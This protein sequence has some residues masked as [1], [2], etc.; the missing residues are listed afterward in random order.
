MRLKCDYCN[1]RGFVLINNK[2][3]LCRACLGTGFRRW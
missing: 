1:G 2:K 3:V